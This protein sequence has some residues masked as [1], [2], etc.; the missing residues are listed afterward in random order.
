MSI[1]SQNPAAAPPIDEKLLK[2]IEQFL[3]LEAT[4]LDERRYEEWLMLLAPDISYVMPARVDRLRRDQ[5]RY[6]VSD[7]LNLFDDTY[8][9]LSTRV[10]RI[11]NGACWTED[12]PARARHFISNVQVQ[13]GDVGGELK[14]SSYYLVTVS[15]MD[16]E[17]ATFTGCRHDVLRPV[18]DG[19]WKIARRLLIGDQSVISTNEL[20]IFF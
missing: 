20:T 14:V 8:T 7:E 17:P 12:P 10:R 13:P 19:K 1:E 15:R 5:A 9:S 2:C 16:G 18:D 11:R 6:T 4:L 3:Y